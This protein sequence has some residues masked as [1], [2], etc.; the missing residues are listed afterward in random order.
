MALGVGR[1]SCRGGDG[2]RGYCRDRP[3]RDG[4]RRVEGAR[5]RSEEMCLKKSDVGRVEEELDGVAASVSPPCMKMSGP[6]ATV[7]KIPR[8]TCR[9]R[10]CH[11]L[12]PHCHQPPLC[13]YQP[14]RRPHHRPLPQS[15][16]MQAPQACLLQRPRTS[17]Q[18][19]CGAR[20]QL[21]RRGSHYSYACKRA[22][23]N[24]TEPRNSMLSISTTVPLRRSSRVCDPRAIRSITRGVRT[25]LAC[26]SSALTSRSRPSFACAQI[27]FSI[28]LDTR[29]VLLA[30]LA[31]I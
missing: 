5:R 16:Y 29:A 10:P 15:Q 17:R 7:L 20:A 18:A 14:E 8:H 12:L 11:Q 24:P 31:Q 2:S 22:H 19:C 9:P 26:A 3:G 21:T 1:R 13:C 30:Q 6:C 27:Y 28:E 25:H 4:V 23:V